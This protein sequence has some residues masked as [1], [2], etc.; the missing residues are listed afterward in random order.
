MD[1]NLTILQVEEFRLAKEWL[2]TNRKEDNT[3]DLR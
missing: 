1:V 2:V 3:C